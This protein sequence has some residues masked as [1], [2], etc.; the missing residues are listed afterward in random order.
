[1]G[2]SGEFFSEYGPV[3]GGRDVPPQLVELGSSFLVTSSTRSGAVRHDRLCG[4]VAIADSEE[5]NLR[6]R[7]ELRK[8]TNLRTNLIETMAVILTH[9]ERC[10]QHLVPVSRS[11]TSFEPL[12]QKLGAIPTP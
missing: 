10:K 12:A 7:V 6:R 9:P 3:R 11:Q 5:P 8:M 2:Y 1:M 4:C